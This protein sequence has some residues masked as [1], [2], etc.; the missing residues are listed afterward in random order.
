[1]GSPRFRRS[2][3][4]GP[5][6]NASVLAELPSRVYLKSRWRSHEPGEKPGSV[7]PDSPIRALSLLH[8]DV[9]SFG[10][11]CGVGPTLWPNP[12][13]TMGQAIK[14]SCRARVASHLNFRIHLAV[15]CQAVLDF[16]WPLSAKGEEAGNGSVGEYIP[17][18][19][20]LPR[21]FLRAPLQKR[22][23]KA[24]VSGL[25]FLSR[26]FTFSLQRLSGSNRQIEL[27]VVPPRANSSL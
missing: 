15:G 22:A 14:L 17:L 23:E 10:N 16:F 27:Q 6:A 21:P 12:P 18:P 3:N 7:G 19:D 11:K 20:T 13:E 8:P 25:S 1:V 9:A 24:S 2:R 4:L 26:V 5:L